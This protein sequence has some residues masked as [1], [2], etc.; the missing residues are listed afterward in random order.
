[1]KFKLCSLSL[2]VLICAFGCGKKQVEPPPVPHAISIE[3]NIIEDREETVEDL[4]RMLLPLAAV[5]HIDISFNGTHI[6][7]PCDCPPVW[8]PNHT[9]TNK[10]VGIEFPLDY[11]LPDVDSKM[12]ALS[13]WV[14]KEGVE[15]VSISFRKDL[16]LRTALL[17]LDYLN[18]NDVYFAMSKSTNENETT[19][20]K[21]EKIRNK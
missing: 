17:V 16:P 1:M 9:S 6:Y 19:F 7:L 4:F 11:D 2:I 14:K 5:G 10:M 20:T 3:V 12:N 15:G 21:L 13:K 8:D 18:E